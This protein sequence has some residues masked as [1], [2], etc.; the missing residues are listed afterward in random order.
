MKFQMTIGK[1]LFICLGA[2]MVL[3]M[4]LGAYALVG[5]SSLGT[6]ME[7]LVNGNTKRQALAGA[8]NHSMSDVGSLERGIILGAFIKDRA[9]MER[10]N[11]SRADA[12]ETV[13]RG[14]YE[15][16]LSGEDA[17]VKANGFRSSKLSRKS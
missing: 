3:T 4:A 1:K 6:T 2:L 11:Q 17:Q 7:R 15:L 13:K 9:G 14:L 10:Y 16:A 8:I 12:A 5:F